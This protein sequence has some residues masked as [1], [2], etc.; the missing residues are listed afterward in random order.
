[1]DGER[2]PAQRQLAS[3]EL[4]Y[5]RKASANRFTA[6][7]IAATAIEYL[8]YQRRA[9]DLRQVGHAQLRHARVERRKLVGLV[10]PALDGTG[11][12]L[13][14]QAEAKPNASSTL[15]APPCC[16]RDAPHRA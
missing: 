11:Q 14:Q 10:F 6:P 7:I 13:D 15:G 12:Y 1:M 16:A 9:A 2:R 8:G 5:S 4:R 3:I